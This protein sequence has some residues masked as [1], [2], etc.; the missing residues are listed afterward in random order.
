[1]IR[2]GASRFELTPTARAQMAIWIESADGTLFR[3]IGLTS[4][5]AYRGIGNRPG[6]TQ[7]NSGYRWPYGRR[8]GVL[9]VW[10]HRR[11][12]A[13]HTT[14]PR[15]IFQHRTSEGYA[16]AS[17]AD[18]SQD[19]YYCLR[20]DRS[21]SRRDALDA[22]TC[23]SVFF[24]DKGRYMTSADVA[25]GY[26][27]PFVM[28]DGTATMRSLS[29]DSLYPPRRDVDRCTS[30][31][32]LDTPDV[33]HYVADARRVMPNIDAVTL[34][35]PPGA[36]PFQTTFVV[37][38]AW[39]DGDYAVFVETNVEGDYN[40]SWNDSTEPTPTAPVGEWDSYAETYGYPYR[41]QPSVVYRV[42]VHVS[43]AGDE[44]TA[45]E[46]LGYGD[47]NGLTGDM[48]AMDATITD[49]AA[50]A[51]GSGADRLM[52]TPRDNRLVVRVLPSNVCAVASPPTGCGAACDA[53]HG[54]GP[55]L[56][57][58]PDGTC[59]GLC[60][61]SM[62]P[63]TV[64]DLA[65]S[66][67]PDEKQS[68]HYARLRFVVPSFPRPVQ[69][70]EVR[71]STAPITDEVSF[72][73]AQPAN[74]ASLDSV[75]LTVPTDG[76]PGDTVQVDFGGLVPT[77][78]YWVGVRA[79]D[80]CDEASPIAVGEVTTTKIYFTTVS[81][82]FVATA[83]YGTPM[84]KDIGS[85]RRFRD[86]HLLTNAPGRALVHLY[87]TVGPY[88]ADVIR[89]SEALRALTRWALAP[90]VTGTR[91]LDGPEGAAVPSP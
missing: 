21:F 79:I 32:C 86:R 84:A 20:F 53:A 52:M 39:P 31:G 70:Y 78:H 25:S 40:G 67:H 91:L 7:M 41:G 66:E 82:C 12:A 85:L 9:P 49:N 22:V 62:P 47:V 60:D 69:S 13:T 80:V 16:S 34:A 29:L 57:C 50:S 27:E 55:G 59:T 8:E 10:A 42:P 81:P 2:S 38:D 48:R 17:Q 1:M 46:P 77:T 3:T 58:G 45:A 33:D 23:A 19:D 54:C 35:T 26:A 18:S 63:P 6:A 61:L 90:L 64:R 44:A 5:V 56:G 65:V 72:L 4:A 24:S 87:Y 76:A 28:P 73:R 37:P 74:A 11:A 36:M 43:A 14:F 89:G 15:I 68:H 83:A 30:P 88:A 51:S 75:A 71:V